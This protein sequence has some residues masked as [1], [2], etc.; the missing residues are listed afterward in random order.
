SDGTTSNRL[1]GGPGIDGRGS[2]QNRAC[3]DHARLEMRQGRKNPITRLR[4]DRVQYRQSGPYDARGGPLQRQGRE[5]RVPL[6]Q[7]QRI[8]IQAQRKWNPGARFCRLGA[9]GAEETFGLIGSF[10]ANSTP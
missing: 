10:V 7:G 3:K 1:L 9:R 8:S 5:V 6:L 4:A 2:R